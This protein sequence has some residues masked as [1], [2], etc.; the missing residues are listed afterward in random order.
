[1]KSEHN[2]LVMQHKV[3]QSHPT[4]VLLEDTHQQNGPRLPRCDGSKGWSPWCHSGAQIAGES[5]A[6]SDRWQPCHHRDSSRCLYGVYPG[7]CASLF[8]ATDPA[9]NWS[10]WMTLSTASADSHLPH[11]LRGNLLPSVEL[12]GAVAG[13]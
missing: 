1:M 13:R 6:D 9:P 11:V 10:R 7:M 4:G 5:R 2:I 3:P 12:L 8:P